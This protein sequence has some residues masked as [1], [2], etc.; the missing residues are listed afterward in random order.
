M[1]GDFD[2]A[3]DA[4]GES[5]GEIWEAD[6]WGQQI[7]YTAYYDT[8]LSPD[9]RYAAQEALDNYIDQY[10][11]ADFDEIFD[12]DAYREWYDSQ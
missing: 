7:L 11:D 1:V 9:L 10:Y 4:L 8:D 6:S 5:L 3:N 12:W 2:W